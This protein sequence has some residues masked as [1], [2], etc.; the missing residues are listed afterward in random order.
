MSFSKDV[1]VGFRVWLWLL[2]LAIPLTIISFIISFSSGLLDLLV[3]EYLVF[4]IVTAVFSIAVYFVLFWFVIGW[5][6]RKVMKE[7]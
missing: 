7:K 6:A 2:L 3:G 5:S 4:T 1:K